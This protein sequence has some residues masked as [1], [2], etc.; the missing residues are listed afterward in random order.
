M[1]RGLAEGIDA[2]LMRERLEALV[3]LND[4]LSGALDEAATI[5]GRATLAAASAFLWVDDPDVRDMLRLTAAVADM[6]VEPSPPGGLLVAAG[7][8]A[9]RLVRRCRALGVEVAI[10]DGFPRVRQS[11]FPPPKRDSRPA[12]VSWRPPPARPR[13]RPNGNGNGKG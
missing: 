12:S 8:D 11:S 2:G 10:E 4:E 1:A 7:V 5:V 9:E 13:R 6:F 3:P